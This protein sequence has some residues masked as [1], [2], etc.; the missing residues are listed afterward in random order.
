MSPQLPG[1]GAAPDAPFP[2]TRSALRYPNGLLAWG[3]DFHPGRML[4]AYRR[5]IFPWSTEGEPILW[6][7]PDPRC[8]IRPGKV[9]LSRRTQRRYHSG[10]YRISADTAFNEVIAGCAAPRREGGGTWITTPLREAF[11]LLHGEGH[12]HS[13]EVWRDELLVGGIY[14]LALGRVF[15]GESMFSLQADVSKLALIALCRQLHAW[16]FPLLDCQV[17]NRHLGS[18][19]AINLPRNAFES[20]LAHAVDLPFERG[21]WRKRFRVDARW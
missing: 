18:M 3:G 7:S 21:S 16:D 13:V 15:F 14:G 11:I 4:A 2:D 17:P 8:V 10:D 1:L 9:H 19:G 6:W 5:G 12:A 20:E